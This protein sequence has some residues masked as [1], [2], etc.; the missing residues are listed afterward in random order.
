MYIVCA[1]FS[2]TEQ[3][4]FDVCYRKIESKDHTWRFCGPCTFVSRR[5]P[6]DKYRQMSRVLA[7][8]GH[9]QS[10]RP[11]QPRLTSDLVIYQE[12]SKT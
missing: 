12:I 9:W 8:N 11:S 7:T 10:L 4:E 5:V 6:L 2:L 1:H 3:V